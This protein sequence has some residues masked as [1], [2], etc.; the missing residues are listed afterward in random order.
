MPNCPL[1]SLPQ[2]YPTPSA[3]RAQAWSPPGEIV[4]KTWPPGTRAGTF[5]IYPPQQYASPAAVRAQLPNAPADKATKII[6][7]VTGSGVE[8]AVSVPGTH[9]WPW[10][11][12]P[13]QRELEK[14]K[15]SRQTIAHACRTRNPTADCPLLELLEERTVEPVRIAR[16]S[17]GANGTARRTRRMGQ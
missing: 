14:L 3:V 7:P 6:P 4:R 13:Q 15:R 9:S 10:L 8:T 5:A 2:Q 16:R 11:F 12:W 1:S 17:R